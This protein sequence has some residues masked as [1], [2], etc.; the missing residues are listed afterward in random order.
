MGGEKYQICKRCVM[1]TT[2]NS[3]EFDKNGICNYC[4]E[5]Y[6]K[7]KERILSSTE[8]KKQLNEIV[9]DIKR[10]GVNKKYDCI[11]GISGGLD[12]TYLLYLAKKFGLRPL[13]VH[14]DNGWGSRVSVKNISKA[15]KALSVDLYTYVINWEEVRDLQLAYLKASVVDMETISD[16]AIKATL[17]N[18]ANE[19]NIKYILT[20]ISFL[21]EGIMGK[22]WTHSKSDYVNIKDIHNKFGTIKLKSYP[23]LHLID[24][25]YFQGIRNI[26]TIEVLNYV[27][28]KVESA[29]K[30]VSEKCG[31]EAY[32]RKHG[33]SFFTRFYQE[34]LLPRKFNIDK[35][36]AHLSAL[37][38]ASQ[39]KREK[40]LKEL[41]KPLYKDEE[42]KKDK[43]FVLR[44]WGLSKEEFEDLM[45]LPIKSHYDYKSNNY[46]F[47]RVRKFYQFVWNR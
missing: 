12:S 27:D 2:S 29:K 47:R 4:K 23:F 21:T 9:A 24:R 5:Y 25:V 19:K 42:L 7:V 1:D 20:G 13:A 38:C 3:I 28:Y 26:R 33:E 44:K 11:V 34:Y 32:E 30:I 16:Q 40:A 43:E 37:I 35:R 15:I 17:Y 10:K 31:W 8:N 46:F 22:G 18:V 36:K 45:N 39:L 14:L 6:V 41:E